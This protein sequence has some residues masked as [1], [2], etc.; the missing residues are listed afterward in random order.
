[1]IFL[2]K[3]FFEKNKRGSFLLEALLAVLI[4]SVGLVGVIRGLL[5]S[6]NAAKRAEEYSRAILVAENVFVQL[7]CLNGQK[8]SSSVM[9]ETNKKSFTAQ[10]DIGYSDNTLIPNSLQVAQVKVHWPG[11]LKQKEIQAVTL[12]SGPV[13][14]KK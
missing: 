10:V 9:L 1:M 14:E 5:S 2:K 8:N 11:A 4:L 12:L 13:D 3:I 7:M 6:L